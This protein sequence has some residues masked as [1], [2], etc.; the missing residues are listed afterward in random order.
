MRA[1]RP[2]GPVEGL[3]NTRSSLGDG[4][5]GGRSR[6]ATPYNERRL[7]RPT[8]VVQAGGPLPR[9]DRVGRW[10]VL[11]PLA[12][13][14]WR[15]FGTRF[16]DEIHLAGGTTTPS[17]AASTAHLV[18]NL[19]TDG[20][21]SAASPPL[22]RM[23]GS[24]GTH[25]GRWYLAAGSDSTDSGS[26]SPS[27]SLMIYTFA[28]DS[29]T[30]GASMPARRD[31]TAGDMVDGKLHV[32]GGRTPSDSWNSGPGSTDHFVYDPETDSWG[33]AAPLPVAGRN[34]GAF[35][36]G[37]FL[38]LLGGGGDA[39]RDQLIRYNPIADQWVQLAD[40]PEEVQLPDFGVVDGRLFLYGGIVPGGALTTNYAYHFVDDTWRA[41]PASQAKPSP[42]GA[43]YDTNNLVDGGRIYS[44]GGRD[45]SDGEGVDAVEAFVAADHAHERGY[46]A[47][48]NLRQFIAQEITEGGGF[49]ASELGELDNVDLEADA[50]D[51]PV[52]LLGRNPEADVGDED[53][54]VRANVPPAGVVLQPTPPS[55][56]SLGMLWGDTD[57]SAFVLPNGTRDDD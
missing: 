18:Y 52:T 19:R 39:P 15:M 5:L 2:L 14:R 23:A 6:I 3:R 25:R 45:A 43:F 31:Q 46:D 32:L 35:E 40:I 29:W 9:Q 13:A 44:F 8:S 21:G 42:S 27:D 7:R 28:T 34:M 26:A 24:S 37:G 38:Y 17:G 4:T 53:E 56:P 55:S 47:R 33:T 16:M 54:W 20:M 11:A 57:G 49:G 10:I 41:L 51:D 22:A 48:V 50:I 1:R 30:T 12:Q 36:Y